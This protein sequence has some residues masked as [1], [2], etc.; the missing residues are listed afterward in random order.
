[1]SQTSCDVSAF[2]FRVTGTF[3]VIPVLP[4]ISSTKQETEKHVSQ[5]S[6]PNGLSK[7]KTPSIL[8]LITQ[9]S[10]PPSYKHSH[11]SG[12]I[13]LEQPGIKP[14]TFWLIDDPL[15]LLHCSWLTCCHSNC[16]ALEP[17]TVSWHVCWTEWCPFVG[18]SVK[19]G[20]LLF[21]LLLHVCRTATVVIKLTA[22]PRQSVASYSFLA[23]QTL[24]R[25]YIDRIWLAGW[26]LGMFYAGH[27][28]RVWS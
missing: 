3:G 2:N 1:M 14:P 21:V 23:L 5:L 15:C 22:W 27:L 9:C 16:P 25:R 17:E 28:Q 4:P 18:T 13:R 11:T 26:K 10:A 24:S 7:L 6:A 12:C 20:I 8:T 19:A